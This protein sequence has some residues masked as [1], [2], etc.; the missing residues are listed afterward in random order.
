MAITTTFKVVTTPRARQSL[1]M[2]FFSP[3]L[4]FKD[5]V[6]ERALYRARKALGLL[7]ISE[8]RVQTQRIGPLWKDN[9]TRNVFEVAEADA[10]WIVKTIE[11]VEKSSAD[12]LVIE[13]LL[14][15]L[16]DKRDAPPELLEGALPYDPAAELA[17]W[18]PSLEPVIE[19]PALVVAV[20]REAA[21]QESYMGWRDTLRA[22]LGP[23]P[24]ETE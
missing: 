24:K 11:S 7:E 19:N 17:G 4:K 21:Q 5:R 16:E 18:K 9:T 8:Q 22:A 15:Q 23:G 13:D 2:L 12:L 1:A 20:L 3:A 14:G 10:E 6:R